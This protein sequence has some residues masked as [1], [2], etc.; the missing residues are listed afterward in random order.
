V[1]GQGVIGLG[2]GGVGGRELGVVAAGVLPVGGDAAL[3]LVAL[4]LHL[5]GGALA[6][7][8]GLG[9][10]ALA[11][12]G[13]LGAGGGGG[14]LGGGGGFGAGALAFAAGVGHGALAAVLA[15]PARRY[16]RPRR[17]AALAWAASASARAAAN[18]FGSASAA[19]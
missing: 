13:A 15:R 12:G 7:G 10:G 3:E 11:G 18:R 14:A 4:L 5:G 1:L 17:R 8:G 2:D 19:A 6:G 9:G 16:E